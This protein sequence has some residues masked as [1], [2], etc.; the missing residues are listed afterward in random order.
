MKDRS[1]FFL[2]GR[3]AVRRCAQTRAESRWYAWYFVLLRLGWYWGQ[4]LLR[5]NTIGWCRDSSALLVGGSMFFHSPSC[6]NESSYDDK[7]VLQKESPNSHQTKEPFRDVL[8]LPARAHAPDHT[9]LHVRCLCEGALVTPPAGCG[10][11][12]V[13]RRISVSWKTS[14]AFEA[15][16]LG[17]SGWQWDAWAMCSL[18]AFWLLRARVCRVSWCASR[19]GLS[20]SCLGQKRYV[21]NGMYMSGMITT[22]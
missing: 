15:N 19:G 9:T 4:Q 17:A 11:H 14:R 13:F 2:S 6:G 20:T 3:Y 16:P 10:A 18:G 22:V 5:L 8:A 12:T 1:M 7:R 21:C